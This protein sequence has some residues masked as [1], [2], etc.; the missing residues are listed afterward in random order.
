[1]SDCPGAPAKLVFRKMHTKTSL[2]I[3]INAEIWAK[4]L[5]RKWR[6]AFL[7]NQATMRGL[8]PLI[9]LFESS[10]KNMENDTTF[11][12]MRSGDHLGDAKMSRKGISVAPSNL[13]FLLPVI[14]ID[15]KGFRRMKEGQIYKILPQMF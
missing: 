5:L 1:M 9:F 7:S 3:A 12:R 14:A 4:N 10:W 11:V 6:Y 15:R 13:T 8:S 2:M